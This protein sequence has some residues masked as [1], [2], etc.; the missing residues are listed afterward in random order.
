M[1][2]LQSACLIAVLF[3]Q[4]V[5]GGETPGFVIRWGVYANDNGY[6]N[7]G[8][9]VV[10]V[11]A[12]PL[13][14][15]VQIAAGPN[16]GLARSRDGS[17][18]AWGS[19]FKGETAVPAGLSNVISI[20]AGPSYSVALKNSGQIVVWGKN[21]HQL[22]SEYSGPSYRKQLAEALERV[23]ARGPDEL[24]EVTAIAAMSFRILALMQNGKVTSWPVTDQ[25][26]NG[27]SNV[28]GIAGVAGGYGRSVAIMDN[29]EVFGWGSQPV[30]PNLEPP[31][32][33]SNVVSA[34]LGWSHSL[35]LKGDGTVFGWGA[36]DRGQATGVST[37]VRNKD[38]TGSGLVSLEGVMLTDVTAIAAAK[39]F[40]MAL[41]RNGSIVVWGDKEH[42]T[43][44]VP[45]GLSNVVAIAAGETFCL[46]IT[47]NATV[48]ERFRH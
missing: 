29:G 42:A 10:S 25:A 48:A 32:G 44:E 5:L 36:N 20:C 4:H 2:I 16:H 26:V 3:S 11:A 37:T 19:N 34:A 46:A 45:A 18:F 14:N 23:W 24:N 40:S 27:L 21:P 8:T 15:I 35:A 12:K 28:V 47:T 41:K 30:T 33:M 17:V 39:N 9:G 7:R 13:T 22:N 1:K 6:A 38:R 31:P 43:F